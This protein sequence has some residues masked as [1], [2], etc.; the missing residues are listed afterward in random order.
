[1]SWM[2]AVWAGYAAMLHDPAVIRT[3]L[4]HLGLARS[5]PNPRPRAARGLIGSTRARQAPCLR[6]IILC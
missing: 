4:A 5:G 6:G 1:M 3:L 2:L